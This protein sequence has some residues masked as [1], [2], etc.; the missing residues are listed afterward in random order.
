MGPVPP[1]PFSFALVGAGRVGTAVS[2]LLVAAGHRAAGVASRRSEAAEAAAVRLATGTFEPRAGLPKGVDVVLIGVPERAVGALAAELAPG[3]AEGTVVCHFAG[4]V[5]LAPLEEVVAAGAL[6]AAL[7]PV[8]ACPD[9]DTAIRRLPGSAWGV[10]VSPALDAWTSAFVIRD[11]GGVPVVVREEHR[12][13]WHAAAAVTSNG[14]AALLGVGEAMLRTIGL[15]APEAV[16]GPLATG[17]VANAREGGGG[18]ATLTGP[19]VRGEID[20]IE[21]HLQILRER[22]PD[23]ADLYSLVSRTVLGIAA[24]TGRIG[25]DAVGELRR[26]LEDR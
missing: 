7:H 1:H 13:L 18:T 4:S 19:V 10:T 16:L 17:T 21:A 8:Q 26:V 14:I 24:R 12:A 5:G 23:L 3:L 11:L 6:G 22:A 25:D 9:V 15:Q 20:T 2:S